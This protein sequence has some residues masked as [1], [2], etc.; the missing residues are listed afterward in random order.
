MSFPR[1]TKSFENISN[2]NVSELIPIYRD[3]RRDLLGENQS[4]MDHSTTQTVNYGPIPSEVYE[5]PLTI[6]QLPMRNA[7]LTRHEKPHRI[8]A[9]IEPYQGFFDKRT[10]R[11]WFRE[12]DRMAFANHWT[13][14][15]KAKQVYFW[16][17]DEARRECGSIIDQFP[18]IEYEDLRGRLEK[19]FPDD[20]STLS[21][22]ENLQQRKLKKNEPVF[23]YFYDKMSLINKYNNKLPWELVRDFIVS[24]LSSDFRLDLFKVHGTDATKLDSNEKLRSALKETEKWRKQAK[25]LRPVV[26]IKI[27]SNRYTTPSRRRRNETGFEPTTTT[28]INQHIDEEEPANW[29]QLDNDIEEVTMELPVENPETFNELDTQM[30]DLNGPPLLEFQQSEEEP[31]VVEYTWAP[32]GKPICIECGVIGHTRRHCPQR[33]Q[34]RYNYLEN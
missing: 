23:V 9:L 7:D 31:E 24:G 19:I 33:R 11:E 4:L 10:A 32:N 1:R 16:L 15:Y 14:D 22:F 34:S 12:Y 26:E 20:V 29:N 21:H 27:D 3:P 25:S 13:S 6:H 5:E 17:E 30:D 2:M 28:N 8:A 18:D